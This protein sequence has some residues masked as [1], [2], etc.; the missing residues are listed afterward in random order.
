MASFLPAGWTSPQLS[1]SNS[2]RFK[3]P[4]KRNIVP[5]TSVI[6]HCATSSLSLFLLLHIRAHA[7]ELE[8]RFRWNEVFTHGQ[9]KVK[10]KIGVALC[11]R[12]HLW[13]NS[14]GRNWVQPQPPP[15]SYCFPFLMSPNP[16]PPSSFNPR[17][18]SR[19]RQPALGST[20]FGEGGG[21]G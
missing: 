5:E 12:A 3:L 14:G 19:L 13:G 6:S 4:E 2:R 20:G 11:F 7:H 9:T 17:G 8:K 10:K 18:P 1:L 15:S 16:P 21:G